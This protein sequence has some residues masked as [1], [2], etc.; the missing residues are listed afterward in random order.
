MFSVRLLHP[1]AHKSNALF[2]TLQA[3]PRCRA[4]LPACH[5]TQNVKGKPLQQ[6]EKAVARQQVR[7][8]FQQRRGSQSLTRFLFR[9]CWGRQPASPC[10]CF[11][12]LASAGFP[13]AVLRLGGRHPHTAAG[14]STHPF[15]VCV[16]S[17]RS[18][19]YVYPM[20]T[21]CL[22]YIPKHRSR[23][24]PAFGT[25]RTHVCKLEFAKLRLTTFVGF[26]SHF[27]TK[28]TF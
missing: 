27:L 20:F 1:S 24:S 8:L 10:P 13:L 28:R 5:Q 3:L 14:L 19:A 26:C 18:A 9:L 22:V 7:D 4:L 23:W 17:L 6:G 11:L 21:L 2:A 16:A 25:T 12:L 15:G